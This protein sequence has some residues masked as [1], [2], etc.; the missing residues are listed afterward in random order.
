MDQTVSGF[1]GAFGVA[2]L[3]VL[4]LTR[5]APWIGLMDQPGGRK[6]HIVPTPVVGGIAIFFAYAMAS[7]I[8]GIAPG[9]YPAFEA[10]LAVVLMIGVIDDASDLR[11][12][13]KLLALAAAAVLMTAPGLVLASRIGVVGGAEI[14]LGPLGLPVTILMIVGLANAWNMIDGIDG[15]A[16]GAAIVALACLATAAFLA[17]RYDLALLII[18]LSGATLGFLVFN[19][20]NPWLPHAR[21]F[22][23]DA[24]SLTLGAAIAWLIAALSSPGRSTG[25]EAL[26]LVALAWTVCV[27]AFDTLSLIARRMAAGRSPMA[28]DREHL[29]H[30]LIEAGL[31][32][33]RAAAAIIAACA[34]CGAIG[35]GGFALGAPDAVLALGLAIPLAVH[36]AFVAKI[37]KSRKRAFP[38]VRPF[39]NGPVGRP[40]APR[41]GVGARPDIPA[42]PDL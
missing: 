42:G 15:A 27:P 18:V 6:A 24:G 29:H 33:G 12:R 1:L 2:A 8:L 14:A 36:G 11:P 5:A 37:T 25:V 35:V 10:G 9:R 23:G 40:L 32:P 38:T 7:A 31:S 41:S 26:P 19:M 16:G 3:L 21:A 17:T 34:I 4:V 30:L 20:R 28:A 22:L 13:L 39:G